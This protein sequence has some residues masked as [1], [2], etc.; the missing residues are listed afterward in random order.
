MPLQHV[1][2]DS[3]PMP[4]SLC[5]VYK[6]IK[7]FNDWVETHSPGSD[8]DFVSNVYKIANCHPNLVH[9]R[10]S[11]QLVLRKG[12]Y[13]VTLEQYGPPANPQTLQVMLLS[14]NCIP[15]R[16]NRIDMSRELSPC[17]EETHGHGPKFAFADEIKTI[18]VTLT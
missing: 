4:F 15:S 10:K 11:P 7:R 12:D 8:F 13:E 16:N 5:R 3:E 17:R 1:G 18:S 6:Q 14:P 2:Q 9:T